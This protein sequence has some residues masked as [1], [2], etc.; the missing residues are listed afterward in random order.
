[1][2]R[3]AISVATLALVLFAAQMAFASE[4][5]GVG[6]MGSGSLMKNGATYSGTFMFGLS[7]TWTIDV[8]DSLWPDD[9]DSTARWNYLWDFFVYDDTPGGEAWFGTFDLSTLGSIPTFE[10]DSTRG[11]L[12]GDCTYRIMI[13]DWNGDGVL[14]QR[15]K[16]QQQQLTYTLS[17]NPDLGTSDFDDMCGHGSITSYSF[18]FI[19]PPDDNDLDIMGQLQL[20]ECP[21]PVEETTW[22]TIKS[23][24]N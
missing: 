18:K 6:L 22:G 11:M 9:S 13:R 15:E 21:S 3:L 1:M 5:I 12:A 20:N 24:Y 14:S 16:H 19:N 4:N 10:F 7:G 23:L 2:K 17:I 8:D